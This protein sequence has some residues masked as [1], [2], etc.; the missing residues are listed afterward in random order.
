[1]HLYGLA[2]QIAGVLAD[3][4]AVPLAVASGTARPRRGRPPVHVP[5]PPAVPRATPSI[6][7]GKTAAPV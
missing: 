5:G 4:V 6:R 7:H 3:R 1:M 2:A